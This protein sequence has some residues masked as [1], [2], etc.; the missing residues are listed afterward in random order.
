MPYK[1]TGN[2]NGRPKGSKNLSKRAGDA[3]IMKQ[4][5]ERLLNSRSAPKVI[6]KIFEAALD[7]NHK[8]QAAAWKMV[9]DRIAPLSAFDKV[10][11]TSPRTAI[12][13]NISGVGGDAPKIETVDDIID[14][15][16]GAEDGT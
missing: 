13:V 4:Y 6:Q 7:D 9:V 5:R 3:A 2:P 1:P 15:Q 11:G 16:D 14:T 10:A 12:Q 8:N